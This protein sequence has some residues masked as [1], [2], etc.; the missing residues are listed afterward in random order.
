[1]VVSSRQ[2]WR[3]NFTYESPFIFL[4]PLNRWLGLVQQERLYGGILTSV[5]AGEF[6][7]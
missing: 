3:G 5:L 1:M 7:L 4:K 2:Y 6:H